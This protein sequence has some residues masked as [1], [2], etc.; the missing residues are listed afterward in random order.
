MLTQQRLKELLTYD[1]DSGLFYRKLIIGSKGKLGDLA[2]HISKRL[3]YRIISVDGKQYLAH[4]LAW[5]Y[6]YGEWPPYQ[7][8]HI[9]RDRTDNKANNLRLATNR[10]EQ[11][12]N[13]NIRK[14]NTSGH[15]GVRWYSPYKKLVAYITVNKKRK[16]IG[17]FLNIEDAITARKI[18]K[19]E[20]HIYNPE[21]KL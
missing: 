6:L 20:F 12:Q 11:M 14:D 15:Q 18:F 17:Y 8:D 2:G 19:K 3:G 4:R 10:S 21:N 1:Y 13:Q 9:N 16:T 5:L 7:V